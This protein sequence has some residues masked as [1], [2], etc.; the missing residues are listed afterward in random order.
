MS[1]YDSARA[2]A[3]AAGSGPIDWGAVTE[4]AKAA[5]DPGSLALSSS[6]RA[7]YASDVRDARRRVRQV[8]TLEFDVPDQIQI[9]NRHHWIDANVETF[10]RVMAPLESHAGAFPNLARIANT[11]SMTVALAF[12]GTH[13][14]G[15]YDPI[16]L[17]DG[18]QRHALYF[19]HPNIDRVAEKLDLDRERF[20]RWIAFHEV[21]HAAEFGAAPWL[22]G[23]LERR[24]ELAVESL[25]DGHIEREAMTQLDA[26]MTVVE[27]Y[28]EL[29]MDEAFDAE[30]QD[31]RD[32]LDRQRRTG[33]S[34]LQHLLRRVLGL[35]MKRRQYERGKT[36]FETVVAESDLETA[37]L[38]WA[39][40]ANLPT[41]EELD[42]PERWLARI[43]S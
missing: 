25:A 1:L 10:Q 22:S 16:L 26:A 32:A 4:A 19:V 6:D 43:H 9:F 21:T 8:S 41:D 36:F 23:Y 18:E 42:H 12:L 30:Y 27:G 34:P 38:V 13:V 7:G 5:T 39:T 11:G 15:Q 37:S 40:P 29:L 17:A 35:G 3:D 31:L 28:A 33:G 24:L 20:R 2:V 14:L